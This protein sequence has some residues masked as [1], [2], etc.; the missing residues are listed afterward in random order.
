MTEAPRRFP[1][2]WHA[3][4]IPGGY[5][6]RDA[7]KQAIAYVYARDTLT[8]AMQAKVLTQDGAR[9]IAINIVRLPELLRNAIIRRKCGDYPCD[10][11]RHGR[12]SE[13][14][15][16]ELT[17]VTSSLP[18]VARRR[19]G[20]WQHA[21]QAL[22]VIGF[23]HQGLPLSLP[24]TAA[25]LPRQIAVFSLTFPPRQP[26]A[27]GDDDESRATARRKQCP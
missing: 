3:D 8:E 15:S 4:K 24:L 6:A 10:A 20:L 7:N 17:G 5:V 23:L 14:P 22:S 26:C 27:S 16:V 11:D 18:L 21:Q 25:F 12:T 1:A 9:R 13:C 2:P 19:C